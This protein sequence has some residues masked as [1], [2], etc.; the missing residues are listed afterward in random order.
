[1]KVW[2]ADGS[3]KFRVVEEACLEIVKLKLLLA[4]NFDQ[5]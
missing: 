5:V 2:L 1:M 4:L 3:L